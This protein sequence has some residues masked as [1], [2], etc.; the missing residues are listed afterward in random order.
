MFTDFWRRLVFLTIFFGILFSVPALGASA[1][2]LREELK[3]LLQIL[4][5]SEPWEKWLA[6]SGELPPDW[7]TMPRVPELPDP[8]LMKKGDTTVRISRKE[9][10]AP[11][12]QQILDLFHH[13]VFGSAPPAPGNVRVEILESHEENAVTVQKVMLTFGPNHQA[14]LSLELMIPQ[15]KGPF[16]VF[17]T[18][19]YQRGWAQIAVR[20]GYLACAYAGSDQQDD[21]DNFL[22]AWPNYDWTRLRR[23]A[24]AASRCID[25]LVTLPMVD[26][27]K[28]SMAG[29]SRNGKVS[30][31]AAALDERIAAVVSGNS[32]A[33]GST[34]F[35]L[36]G[37]TQFGESIEGLTRDWPEWIHPRLRFFSGREDRLPFDHN[38][39]IAAIA[40]RHCLMASSINDFVEDPWGIQQVY[41]S[42]KTVYQFL[43]VPDH[44]A[45]KWRNGSHEI[46]SQDVEGFLDWI[47]TCFGRGRYSFPEKL[48]YPRYAEWL[49]SAEPVKVQDFPPKGLEDLLISDEAQPITT[50]EG[51]EAKRSS[52]RKKINWGLGKDPGGIE[53][54][55][56]EDKYD[57]TPLHQKVLLN[58]AEPAAISTIN[59]HTPTNAQLGKESIVFGEHIPGD[60]YYSVPEKNKGQKMPAILWLHPASFSNGYSAF[61]QKG[62]AIHLAMASEGFVVMA[63]DAIGAGL[64]VEEAKD[65]YTRMPEWSFLGKMVRDARNAIS[66]L[67]KLPYVDAQHI[68]VVG[69]GMGAMTALHTAALDE[70]VAGVISVCGFTPMRLDTVEKGTGGI[71]RF[72]QDHLLQPRLGAYIGNESRIP[73]DYHEVLAMIAPRPLVVLSPQYDRENTIADVT[74]CVEEVRKVYSLYGTADQ[75][76][77]LTPEDFNRYSPETQQLVNHKLKT[78][79][80]APPVHYNRVKEQAGSKN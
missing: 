44:L 13:Y 54:K 62:E 50:V 47:D 45:L 23:R 71:R 30:L 73:Y 14:H 21:T 25:Y 16:P 75:L 48:Y 53:G 17:L 12:R 59:E 29:H 6:K 46:M 22:S 49:T 5:K 40:P 8:L 69:Y 32:G 66:V 43:D 11:R 63:F 55:V 56:L 18:Q 19:Q 35:R 24:F 2:K 38:Q 80:A 1:E 4:P 28:I 52:L 39:L 34:A 31:F 57:R 27:Q 77:Q 65:F 10:W 70:R 74:H 33:G 68:Y 41:L 15:G 78:M 67:E 7:D 26:R 51:W 76:Q 42:A 61:Y 72:S 36:F 9:D 79:A 60:L 64:R 3:Q 58:R 37:E 20:R